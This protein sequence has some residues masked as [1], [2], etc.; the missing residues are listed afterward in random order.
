MFKDVLKSLR[1]SRKITQ[2]ELGNMLGYGYTAISNYESGRNEPSINDLIRLAD[3][4]NVSLDYLTDRNIKN[5][6]KE[7]E[8]EGYKADLKE[9]IIKLIDNE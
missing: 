4:F 7:I 6:D 5:V 2:S 9:R 1:K 8:L 3:Y